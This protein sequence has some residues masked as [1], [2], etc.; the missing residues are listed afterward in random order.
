MSGS[1]RAA[2][3]RALIALGSNLG[4]RREH[5]EAA[6]ARLSTDPDLHVLV[7][8]DWYETPPV[9]GPGGQGDYLNGV[10]ELETQ[11]S[12][13]DLLARLQAVEDAGGRDR[14]V[15]RWGP[16][17]LDLDL[18]AYGQERIDEPDLVG[19]HPR[20][21]ERVFVLRPLAQIDP[22]RRLPGSDRTVGERL[23]ELGAEVEHD[24]RA[25]ES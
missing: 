7:V 14:S 22:D 11:L 2:P 4:D 21:A 6:V 19:P 18:I 16:R 23:L 17:T 20:A 5:L 8:S 10:L 13:R 15:P 12:A 24:R 25:C 1:T 9:G 3:V